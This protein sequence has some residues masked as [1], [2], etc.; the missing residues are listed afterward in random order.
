MSKSLTA[1]N[2]RWSLAQGRAA[3]LLDR[4]CLAALVEQSDESSPSAANAGLA[5]AGALEAA[6]R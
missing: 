2:A 5:N 1:I 3:L 6:T 4:L